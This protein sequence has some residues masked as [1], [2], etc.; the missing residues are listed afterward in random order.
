MAELSK[1]IIE[2]ARKLKE[3][4]IGQKISF[5][6]EIESGSTVNSP[7]SIV[8]DDLPPP[9]QEKEQAF[10]KPTLKIQRS[11]ES[12]DMMEP[13]GNNKRIKTDHS[14]TSNDYI[15]VPIEEG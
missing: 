13:D 15:E 12:M 7:A 5:D 10:S 3:K 4:E 9:E 1:M 11:N 2:E 6:N 8:N 14:L